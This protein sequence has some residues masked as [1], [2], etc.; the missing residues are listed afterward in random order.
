V[1]L[2]ARRARPRAPQLRAPEGDPAA[3]NSQP[4]SQGLRIEE[5]TREIQRP[6]KVLQ[7]AGIKR[8]CVATRVLG[9]SGRAM[10]DALVGGTTDPEVLAELARGRLRSK[11]PALREASEGHF[12]SHHA[13]VVG[14]ILAHVDYLDGSIA[15]L[16]AEVERVNFAP[17]SDKVELLD[18]IAGVDRRTAEVLI[19]EIG[20][21]M[22]QFPT[23]R[24]LASWAGMCPGNG[25]SAGKRSS[26]KTRK[27]SKW[28]RGALVDR[29]S[30]R[31]GALQGGLPGGAVR[32][33][34]GPR[35]LQE[36][37]GGGGALHPRDLLPHAGAQPTLPRAWR[38]LPPPAALGGSVQKA[39]GPAVGETRAQGHTGGATPTRVGGRHPTGFSH[40]TLFLGNFRE[41]FSETED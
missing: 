37:G 22:E 40:Q 6:D 11:L 30:P 34:Q 28:L 35:W 17:F 39:A 4:L 18:T 21:D 15:E 1:D 9:A 23:H 29:G 20:A 27:G 41:S 3:E 19:A 26:G 16:S 2:P 13:L 8:S 31:R 38:R 10:L 5:R 32:P 14:M 24:H 33:P 7:D 25:E 12:S 36:S